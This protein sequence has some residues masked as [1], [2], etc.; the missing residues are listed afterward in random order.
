M[1]EKNRLNDIQPIRIFYRTI[2][3]FAITMVSIFV[4]EAVVMIFM[5]TVLQPKSV[6]SE[7]TADAL[8]LSGL[9]FLP[10]YF[11][12]LRPMMRY[13]ERSARAE[14]EVLDSNMALR[15]E[16]KERA[17]VES[18]LRLFRDLL[19]HSHDSILVID[20][21]TS[22][23]LDINDTA[24]INLGYSKDELLDKPIID[25]DG[26]LTDKYLWKE[27]VERVRHKGFL[28]VEGEHIRHDGKAFPVEKNVKLVTEGG[29][30]YI[31]TV[32]RDITE[33]RKSESALRA[34]VES[35]VGGVG[36]D[37]FD[38]I[39]SSLCDWLD[40]DVVMIG[41]A[42][43]DG[44][45]KTLS[46]Q[47]DSE[48][49]KE[50]S[51]VL[52]GTPCET[53]MADGYTILIS[54]VC[55]RF[56]DNK[57]LVDLGAESYIGVPLIDKSGR[58]IGVL[59]A[60][61]RKR[62][63]PPQGAQEVLRIIAGRIS[64]EIERMKADDELQKLSH[65][66]EQSPVTIVITNADGNIEYVNPKFTELTG[67]TP[68]EV[69]GKNPRILKSSV[70]STEFYE[71]LWE[72]IQSGSDWRGEFQNRKKDG[73]LYWEDATISPVLNSDGV[74]THYLAVKE[75]ITERK[76]AEKAIRASEERY[77][78]LFED[79]LDAVFIATPGGKLLDI[80]A[81]GVELFGYSSLEDMFE[82]DIAE[83][84]YQNPAD[85]ELLVKEIE[86]K[87]FVRDF[88]A[89]MKKK[90]G[91]EIIVSIT[92]NAVR[93]SEGRFTA[94]R[95]IIRDNTSNKG[96]EAQLLQ[97]Q[98]MEAIGQL[99][100]GVAH[101]FNNI[102]TSIV[103][104]AHLAMDRIGEEHT[105]YAELMQIFASAERAKDLTRQLLIFSHKQPLKCIP[106]SLN[107]SVNGLS[108]MLDRLLGEDYKIL[109]DLAGKLFSIEA[110]KGG[111]D[112]LIMNL[113]VNA[114]DSMPDGGNIIIKTDNVV[115]DSDDCFSIGPEA[116]PGS[117]VH[118]SVNDS[119]LGISEKVLPRIFE[120]FYTTKEMGKGT[121]LGLSVVHGI[122]KKHGGWIDVESKVGE[123]TTFNAYFPASE[124]RPACGSG[125]IGMSKKIDGGGARILLVE[126]DDNVRG[127]LVLLLKSSGYT[128]FEAANTKIAKDIF[129]QENG[130]FSVL[131][132]DVVMPDGNG[133]QLV[134]ELKQNNPNLNVLLMSGHMD[135]KSQWS[136]IKERGYGFLSKPYTVNELLDAVHNASQNQGQGMT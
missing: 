111:V 113:T 109:P 70:Y 47:L 98:K 131:L 130:D 6:Y 106:L 77:R 62:L 133:L 71:Q 33:R 110:D 12:L 39:V 72:T 54:G 35:T 7:A 9:V 56:P 100:G 1:N 24:C 89:L 57:E 45:V 3:L 126:D 53:T 107:D 103:L 129:E 46:M 101:D 88:E 34:L 15:A 40:V 76:E 85:R 87:G 104:F 16:M 97:S 49:V 112:Q 60:I 19:D 13:V 118:L 65:A 99:A 83:N 50:Y 68:E 58:T 86:L 59:N 31:I 119:G 52:S 66:V 117:F 21:D 64:L 30:E 114:R 44:T 90:D 92:S 136:V 51:Y 23:L 115:L 121:G 2:W 29:K 32:V 22:R 17:K 105:A 43:Q 69:I 67:Y 14:A 91:T 74:I 82:L 11:L 8:M 134:T 135:G 94:Y 95:G 36:R 20:P 63:L 96:L 25:V 81:A 42:T 4:A 125:L 108:K 26:V 79:S 84:F 48:I 28:I 132:S 5:E 116:R 93:D 127:P 37:F 78:T 123:G 80:N 120:P 73:G 75:D 128:V 41:E 61:S 18:D 124:K 102:L 10:L 122:V 38:K 55:E 27:H